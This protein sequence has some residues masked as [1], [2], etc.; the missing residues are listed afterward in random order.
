MGPRLESCGRPEASSTS[1]PNVRLP[2]QPDAGDGG[3]GGVLSAFA[4]VPS[5]QLVDVLDSREW[6][7]I[8]VMTRLRQLPR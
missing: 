2:A 8:P 6:R 4:A 7:T 3:V 5:P 1:T